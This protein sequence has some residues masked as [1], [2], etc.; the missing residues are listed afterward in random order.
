MALVATTL[1]AVAPSD[2]PVALAAAQD[3]SAAP[4]DASS[5]V[6]SV[7]AAR[8]AS[9]LAPLKVDTTMASAAEG[10]AIWMAEN[11]SLQHAGDIVVGAPA[12]WTKVGEN[13]GR[14]GSVNSV[15]NAFMASPN[16]AANVL[17]PAYT[18]IGVGVVWTNDGMLYTTHR[19]AATS[20]DT[21]PAPTPEPAPSATPVP[22]PTA[23]PE[24]PPTTSDVPAPAPTA[25][26][27]VVEPTP[28]PIATPSAPTGL[29]FGTDPIP[30]VGEP[31]RLR[32]TMTLLLAASD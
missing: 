12:D 20:S 29:A 25:V 16:H 22:A 5:F 10:W 6:D 1:V 4:A 8:S 17:D 11:D 19:F 15:W 3:W 30:P 7:N 2:P 21:A 9:G 18:R 28:A 32:A 14:G 26:P 31:E 24:P 23:P 27:V 13:V